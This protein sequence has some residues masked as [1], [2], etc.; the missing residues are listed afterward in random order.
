[1]QHDRLDLLPLRQNVTAEPHAVPVFAAQGVLDWLSRPERY[2]VVS[3][4]GGG[5]ILAAGEAALAEAQ[6]MLREAYGASIRFGTPTV[7]SFVDD[8]T[9]ERM[10]P[11]LFMR[12]DAP[13]AEVERLQRLLASRCADVKE[14]ELQQGRVVLRAEMELARS[15]GVEA[16][17]LDATGGAAQ[18][19][20]WL[21]RYEAA[22]A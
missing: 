18:I 22:R 2:Q 16:E 21:L 7:H 20:S 3:H 8:A 19:L 17:V 13:R 10:V 1:M 6:G 5:Q 9:G 11:V 15:L 14:V 12:V 4:G